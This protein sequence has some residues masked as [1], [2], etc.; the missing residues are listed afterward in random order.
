M[1]AQARTIHG[2]INCRDR[3]NLEDKHRLGVI[4]TEIKSRCKHGE[5]LPA[6]KR[7]EIPQQRASEAMRIAKLPFPVVSAFASQDEALKHIPPDTGEASEKNEPPKAPTERELHCAKCK[8]DKRT[9]QKVQ[10]TCRECEK[11]AADD[12]RPWS[13]FKPPKRKKKLGDGG[14]SAVSYKAHLRRC[15]VHLNNARKDFGFQEDPPEIAER[16]ASLLREADEISYLRK[17]LKERKKA[18]RCAPNPATSSSP[19]DPAP[20]ETTSPCPSDSATSSNGHCET[21]TSNASELNPSSS[22]PEN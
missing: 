18:M 6:L 1:E 12:A 22:T 15:W 2:L 10:K 7:M 9:G 4:L 11:I 13:G 17:R 5:W 16:R 20:T 14:F 8:R 21:G 19:S 3:E